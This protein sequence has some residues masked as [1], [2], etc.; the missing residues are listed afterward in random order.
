MTVARTGGNLVGRAALGN[1]WAFRRT[2]FQGGN[3]ADTRDKE[4]RLAQRMLPGLIVL[5]L[6]T[7]PNRSWAMYYMTNNLVWNGR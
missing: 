2:L 3:R 5:L 7:L 1:R 4:M 6:M